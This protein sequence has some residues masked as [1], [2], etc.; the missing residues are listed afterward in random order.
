MNNILANTKKAATETATATKTEV[1]KPVKLTDDMM[2]EVKSC[3]FGGLI[4]VD[5]R[6]GEQVIWDNEGDIQV[7]SMEL[8]RSMK[9]SQVAFFKNNWIAV[10]SVLDNDKLT[11]ADVY[12]GLYV[13]QYY[14]D[15][16]DPDDFEKVCYWSVNDIETKVALLVPAAKTNLAVALNTFIENGTLDSIKKIKAFEK[17]LGC[18]LSIPN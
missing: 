1:K 10:V 18:E 8:L 17:A 7:V 13:Q 3:V 6:T 14:K 15:V 16:I 2:V 5:K 9:S 12:K 4:Y 11:P